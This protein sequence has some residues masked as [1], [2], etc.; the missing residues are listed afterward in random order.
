MRLSI[1]ALSGLTVFLFSVTSAAVQFPE[2]GPDDVRVSL[3]EPQ[4]NP[5]AWALAPAA[6]FNPD[7][8][9]ALVAWHAETTDN[10]GMELFARRVSLATG[11]VV[12]E[13]FQLTEAGTPGDP[14]RW[15]NAVGVQFDLAYD[16]A[17]Q[18][19]VLVYSADDD[20][21]GLA[22]QK[23]EIFVVQLDGAS[24][25]AV[26]DP[27]RVSFTAVGCGDDCGD[28]KPWFNAYRPKVVIHPAGGYLVAW[29][30]EA[31]G[32]GLADGEFEIFGQRVDQDLDLVGGQRRL[33]NV[34]PDGNIFG[35]GSAAMLKALFNP[36]TGEYVLLWLAGD[37]AFGLG[38]EHREVFM[39]RYA[40]DTLLPAAP[41]ARVSFSGP[42]LT[43][44]SAGFTDA[45]YN[46]DRQEFFVTWSA[47]VD[48]FLG[49]EIYG[50]RISAVDY[51]MLG[52]AQ[53]ISFTLPDSKT[54]HQVPVP[55]EEGDRYSAT[56]PH[57]TW[58]SSLQQ[59]I[60]TWTA[61]QGVDGWRDGDI[62]VH[63]TLVD[64]ATGAPAG[65]TR[66]VS[67]MGQRGGTSHISTGSWQTADPASGRALVV[68]EGNEQRAGLSGG[69]VEIFGQFLDFD[70]GAYSD[71]KVTVIE[72]SVDAA[73]V[74]VLLENNGA[75]AA[76]ALR[77]SVVMDKALPFTTTV[78]HEG[79]LP[80]TCLSLSVADACLVGDLAP[81]GAVELIYEFDTSTLDEEAT[82]SATIS[83]QSDSAELDDTDNHA[84][85][86]VAPVVQPPPSP[87]STPGNGGGSSGGGAGLHGVLVLL[88]LRRWRK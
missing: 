73:R 81:S 86:H 6:V 57:V 25:V 1:I 56:T 84:E 32:L 29:G 30:A 54:P 78:R 67:E 33:S 72:P 87:P 77:A 17:L 76:T 34:E 7:T 71:I 45:T 28:D 65:V 31:P 2:R 27:V 80:Q 85:F 48:D 43:F 63:A 8:G 21:F 10:S 82:V 19:Y 55:P 68:W 52:A 61:D 15:V 3:T 88:L 38:G 75:T 62:E 74:R 18:R 66:T 14:D 11:D 83:A 35:E 41:P 46:P 70:V 36:V 58:S 59:Y 50:Q 9:E 44:Y 4:A 13:P 40:A 64:G 12:G 49:R 22:D 53:R 39:R 69:K 79:D 60:V 23:F 24:G 47:R 37:H 51:A 20:R 5:G 16:S 26:T 42:D